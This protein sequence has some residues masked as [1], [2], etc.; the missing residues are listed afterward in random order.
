MNFCWTLLFVK[1]LSWHALLICSSIC[2]NRLVFPNW[3]G[4]SSKQLW[5]HMKWIGSRFDQ[6][7]N[8]NCFG[9]WMSLL[10]RCFVCLDFLNIE[11]SCTSSL[12][13][14]VSLSSWHTGTFKSTFPIAVSL[15]CLDLR[16]YMILRKFFTFHINYP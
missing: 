5:H 15:I 13:S 1:E 11:K 7:V 2:R 14:D 6:Q 10:R 4:Y 16:A 3:M 9:T 12:H 8:L